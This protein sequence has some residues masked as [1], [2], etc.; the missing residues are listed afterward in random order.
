MV[1]RGRVATQWDE[2]RSEPIN[3]CTHGD[4]KRRLV[5]KLLRSNTP[6]QYINVRITF[7]LVLQSGESWHT[8]AFG[9]LAEGDHLREPVYGCHAIQPDDTKL[10]H[11][12]GGVAF[13]GNSTDLG[14]GGRL[15]RLNP[16]NLER[17]W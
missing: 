10:D 12:P 6:S 3:A 15:P 2:A 13:P 8:C 14:L 5:Y 17:A 9:I 4:F 1:R 11:L 16:W 7:D